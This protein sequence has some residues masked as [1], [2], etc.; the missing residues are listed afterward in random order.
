MTKQ[1]LRRGQMVSIAALVICSGCLHQWDQDVTRHGIH[2]KKLRVNSDM[3]IG[4]LSEDTVIEDYTCQKGWVHLT[5]DFKLRAFMTAKPVVYGAVTLPK[6]SWIR[7]REGGTFGPCALPGNTDI[8]G[9]LCKGTGGPKGVQTCFYP[10]GQL[11]SYFASKDVVVDGIP[12][13]ASVLHPVKLHEN[14]RL[15]QC[16]LSRAAVIEG[17]EHKRKTSVRFDEKGQVIHE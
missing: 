9:H 3:A 11:S 4:I 15:K 10:S 14:G 7:V 1:W 5:G 13:L 2:F 16:T 17:I 12:C 6:G 8:Q